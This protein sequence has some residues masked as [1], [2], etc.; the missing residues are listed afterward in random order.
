VAAD[1]GAALPRVLIT[2]SASRGDRAIP[3]LLTD[4][5]GRFVL[6]VAD[7]AAASLIATKVGYA[8]TAQKFT[9]VADAAE[10]EVRLP[11]SA[12]ISGRAV[13][14]GGAP[15]PLASVKALRVSADEYAKSG[16]RLE[17][18][19]ETDDVGEF[20]LG[21]LPAG[22]YAVSAASPTPS[23]DLIRSVP[24]GAS[25]AVPAYALHGSTIDLSAADEAAGVELIVNPLRGGTLPPLIRGRRDSAAISGRVLDADSG[26]PLAGAVVRLS[27][28]GATRAITTDTLGQFSIS[29]LPPASYT[30]QASRTGYLTW[31]HGQPRANLPG[32]PIAVGE[33]E[34]KEN[35]D[36][37]LPRGSAVTG[38]VVDEHGEPLQDLVMQVLQLRYVDGRMAALRVA[39]I[40]ERRTDDRGRY[41]LFGLRPGSYVIRASVDAAAPG[42]GRLAGVGYAP[43]YYPGSRDVA[44]AWPIAV[45]A[46]TDTAGLVMGFSQAFAAR[47]SGVVLDTAGNPVAGAVRLS[48][49][50]RPGSIGVDP[51]EEVLAGNGSF[52]FENVPPGDYVLHALAN[53]VMRTLRAGPGVFMT[54]PDD[55]EFAIQSVTIADTGP[56]P[57]VLTTTTGTATLTGRLAVEG[58]PDRSSFA[59]TL[60]PIAADSE[61]GPVVA[62]SRGAALEGNAGFRMTGLV[63]PTRFAIG[64]APEGWYLKSI[65]IQG[66]DVTDRPFNFIRRGETVSG[67]EFVVSTS[68]ASVSGRVVD[69]RDSGVSEYAVAVF[70]VDREKWFEGSR[71]LRFARSGADDSF[72]VSSLPPG[73][74]WVAAVNVLDGNAAG[75]EWQNPAVLDALSTRAQRVSL[76]EGEQRSA[77]LRLIRR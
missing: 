2:A 55:P 67:A 43:M 8:V 70:P 16:L 73:D 59:V 30:V 36:V 60:V 19:T 32:T 41:R 23:G 3:P 37:S 54:L 50:R 34:R 47:V 61:Y 7:G 58:Q 74:Y 65:T 6:S 66:S 49:R 77:T 63:G 72:R 44:D 4:E 22:R 9:A 39:G 45:E 25:P 21:G 10:I 1:T 52:T 24:G 11:R 38:I 15:V 56:P 75:G 18:A 68:G 40:A 28:P 14:S 51:H 48:L 76:R 20:R 69:E 46:R 17:F 57:L 27:G 62:R 53:P 64:S 71:H 26:Q 35:V 29:G 31:Q 5:R 42:I 13:D 33:R 12:A